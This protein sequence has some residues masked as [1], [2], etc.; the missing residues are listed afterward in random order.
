M[1][2]S[3]KKIL[4][5]II[6]LFSF[7]FLFETIY[8][9]PGGTDGDGGHYDKITGEY[10]YHHGYTAHQHTGGECPYK[11]DNAVEH[12]SSSS[13]KSEDI[14]WLACVLS[15]IIVLLFWLWPLL[16]PKSNDKEK[17]SKKGE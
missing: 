1:V 16:I 3:M 4:Y 14:N 12:R 7:Y 17:N 8:A 13:S 9:H 15:V 11:F 2:N 10:H 5:V 6:V